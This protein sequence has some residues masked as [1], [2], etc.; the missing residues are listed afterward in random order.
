MRECYQQRIGPFHASCI[1]LYAINQHT[2][3]VTRV[4]TPKKF[5]GQGFARSL[6]NKLLA[7]C[8]RQQVTLELTVN[9]YGDM[10]RNQLAAWYKRLGF[11]EKP[12]GFFRREPH[13]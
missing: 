12:R 4:F 6:F 2:Y 8:D 11:V 13:V 3:M 10:T 5:R 9:P 1:D 7:D